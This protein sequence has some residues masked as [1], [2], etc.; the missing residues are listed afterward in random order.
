MV[1]LHELMRESELQ[2]QILPIYLSEK[3]PLVLKHLMLENQKI[4]QRGGNHIQIHGF[5]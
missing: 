1:E 2:K 4:A 5:R 3:P